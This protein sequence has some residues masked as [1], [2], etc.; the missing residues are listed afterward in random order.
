[1][2]KFTLT[3]DISP[4]SWTDIRAIFLNMQKIY[5]MQ[6][7]FSELRPSIVTAFG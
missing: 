1:L 3:K 6:P 4:T 5:N 2:N 7:E